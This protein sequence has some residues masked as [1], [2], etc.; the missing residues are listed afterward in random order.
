MQNGYPGARYY[1]GCENVDEVEKLA[2]NRVCQLFDCKWANV[3]PHS[4]AQANMAVQFALLQP[5]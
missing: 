4:G 2:I 1:A 5:R 3:Q